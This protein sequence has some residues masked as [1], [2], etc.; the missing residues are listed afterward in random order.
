MLRIGSN[1]C[2]QHSIITNLAPQTV[3]HQT[4]LDIRFASINK[5]MKLVHINYRIHMTF[6]PP[7]TSLKY[8]P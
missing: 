3:S 2:F 6:G 5:I 8:N 4:W 7:N 1:T